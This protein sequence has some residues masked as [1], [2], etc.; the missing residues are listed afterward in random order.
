MMSG[1]GGADMARNASGLGSSGA[2]NFQD[3]P[4]DKDILLQIR[5]FNMRRLHKIR[6]LDPSHIDKLITIKGIVIRNSDVIPEMK[7]ACFRCDKCHNV[8]LVF[9]I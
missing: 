1:L 7:E 2:E 5:P 8:E 6:D 4:A 9:V 3:L